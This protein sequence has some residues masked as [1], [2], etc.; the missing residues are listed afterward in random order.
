MVSV[1]HVASHGLIRTGEFSPHKRTSKKEQQGNNRTNIKKALIAKKVD[2]NGSDG[3]LQCDCNCK[4][5]K[6]ALIG[7][8]YLHVLNLRMV[9]FELRTALHT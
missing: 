6:H 5:Q 7:N 4:K 8:R 3:H 9:I 2:T 1:Y